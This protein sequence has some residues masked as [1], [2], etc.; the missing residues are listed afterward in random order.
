MKRASAFLAGLALGLPLG[1]MLA[2]APKAPAI[3]WTNPDNAP[4]A[5][6]DVQPHVYEAAE[7]LQCCVQ[8]GG[9]RRNPIH[10]SA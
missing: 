10:L 8:C 1:L 3:D 2:P 4:P 5:F 7:S 6:D 9:G